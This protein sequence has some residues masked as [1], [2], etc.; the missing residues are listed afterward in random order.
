MTEC[1]PP[2]ITKAGARDK[3]YTQISFLPDYGRFGSKELELDTYSLLCKRVH[4]IAG[5]T[6]RN[7]KV[8]LN[9]KK[10]EADRFEKYVDLYI[11][12]LGRQAT[13]KT[14]S[15][16]ICTDSNAGPDPIEQDEPE[17]I[18]QLCSKLVLTL[19]LW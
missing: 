3:D 18:V 7:L 17:G 10:L 14:A 9:G 11:E 5:V 2:K 12:A 13:E 1:K 6:H 19:S 8:E 15:S 16:T 4:D